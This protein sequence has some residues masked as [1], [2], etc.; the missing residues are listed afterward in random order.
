[1]A[2]P[3]TQPGVATFIPE[4]WIAAL[5]APYEKALVFAQPGI[6]NRDYEGVINQKGDTLHV[7]SIG[8]PT[9]KKYDATKDMETE[10]LNLSDT[11]FKIDQGDYFNFRVEDVSA[12]QAAG[13]IK[14]PAIQKAS[15]ALA[16]ESDSYVAKTMTAGA[17]HKIGTAEL[18]KR[19]D[20][21][22]DLIVEL[23]KKL[24]SD[25]TPK[26]GRFLI[27]G[28]E[29][30]SAL[31]RDERFTRVDASGADQTLR[32]GIIGRILGFDVLQSENVPTKSGREFVVAGHGSAMTF[33]QQINKIETA[34]EEKRF[35]D[36]VKGLN[37]YGGKVFR[38]EGLATAEVTIKDP[39]TG[40]G[41]EGNG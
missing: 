10:D 26:D 12:L 32:N 28:P 22:Y 17:K 11:E 33:A 31:L 29:L 2:V 23:R 40:G 14:D 9:V 24:N 21:A 20:D 27:A 16:E 3:Q 1:M 34:R 7:G 41:A 4:Q 37:I 38:P 39:S 30:E 18:A 25:H 36:I 35:A 5:M 6:I 8:S 15:E 13:A 19:G